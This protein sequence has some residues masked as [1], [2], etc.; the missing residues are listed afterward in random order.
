MNYANISSL[1]HGLFPH[2]TPAPP[3][4]ALSAQL[5][6]PTIC[7]LTPTGIRAGPLL[8]GVGSWRGPSFMYGYYHQTQP[9]QQQAQPFLLLGPRKLVWLCAPLMVLMIL[10]HGVGI[11]WRQVSVLVIGY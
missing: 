8:G 10:S 9:A 1:V 11:A 5:L 4:S 2:A 7:S 6:A 3:L